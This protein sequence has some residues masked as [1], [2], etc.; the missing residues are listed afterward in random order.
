MQQQK[1]KFEHE[2]NKFP[3]YPKQKSVLISK[4]N[5]QNEIDILNTKINTLR[6]Q[7]REIKRNFY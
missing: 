2:L 1:N 3:E 6:T 5:V 7:L 4:R